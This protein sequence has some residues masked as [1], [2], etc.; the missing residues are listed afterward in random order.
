MEIKLIVALA[1][2]ALVLSPQRGSAAENNAVAEFKDL[3]AKIQ[4]KLQAGSKTEKELAPELK[5]FDDLIARH[6][7]EKT[8][9]VAEILL[10]EAKLYLQVFDNTDKG[11]ELLKQLQRDFPETEV[12]KNAYRML[13]AIRQQTEAV[14][15]QKS[16]VAGVMFPGFEEKDVAGKPLSL[17]NY[18]GKVVLI[19]FWATWCGPCVN[20]LPKVLQAYE[21]HHAK[22]FEIIGISLDEDL[23]KLAEFTKEKNMAWPQFCDANGWQNKLAMKYGIHSIPAT[24]LLD[25]EGKIIGKNLRGDDLEKA[26]AKA[27]AKH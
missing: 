14:R 1:I 7:S 9:E 21:K 11:T 8:D 2:L 12:G 16:L 4:A 19:D 17:T 26:V 24:Y 15:I 18:L 23:R 10:M 25:G 27:L 5:E 20:E 6:K 13:D 3:E 22:G